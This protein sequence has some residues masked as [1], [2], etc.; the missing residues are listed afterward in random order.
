MRSS[1]RC[2]RLGSS[3]GSVI[4]PVRP[5]AFATKEPQQHE[6]RP[7]VREQGWRFPGQGGRCASQGDLP[8]MAQVG[9]G[10]GDAP[11]CCRCSRV[12]LRCSWRGPSGAA[13]SVGGSAGVGVAPSGAVSG[14]CSPGLGSWMAPQDPAGPEQQV[15]SPVP[16]CRRHGSVAGAGE[17]LSAAV[18]HGAAGGPE[19]LYRGA[20]SG[21]RCSGQPQLQAL[22]VMLQA[23]LRRSALLPAD[24]C[25]MWSR[26]P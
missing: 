11:V 19:G 9:T 26:K 7:K 13:V 5:G 18:S 16:R 4:P 10:A 25:V 15:C 24:L 14:I 20:G 2:R 3:W 1:A 21:P 17:G 22:E 8:P 23:G 6:H 12:A